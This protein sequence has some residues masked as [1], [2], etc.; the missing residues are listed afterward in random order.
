M[1]FTA[2]ISGLGVA[3]PGVGAYAASK[4]GING[5]IRAAALEF[6]RYGITV[7]GVEP[8]NNLSEGVT[9]GRNTAFIGGMTK[10]IPW[11]A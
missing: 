7:N 4:G 5:F 2:S 8:G 9:M 6:A 3:C 1:V 10:A 11:K